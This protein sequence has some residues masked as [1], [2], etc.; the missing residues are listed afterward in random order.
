MPIP[1]P[2]EDGLTAPARHIL[3]ALHPLPGARTF[4]KTDKILHAAHAEDRTMPLMDLFAILARMVQ[5][6]VCRYPVLEAQGNFGSIDGDPPAGMRYTE[7]A[8][9]KDEQPP[10]PRLLCNG[11]WAHSGTFAAQP[12]PEASDDASLIDCVPEEPIQGGEL[13]SFLLPHN[14]GEVARAITLLL[15]RPRSSVEEVL[16]VLPGPD[17]PTGGILT[18]PEALPALYATGKGEARIRARMRVDTIPRNKFCVVISEIPFGM[19]KTDLIERMAAG[20]KD[21]SLTDIAD[22]R[23]MTQRDDLRI[24]IEAARDKDPAWVLH[25]LSSDPRLESVIQVRMVVRRAGHANTVGLIDLLRMSL[26]NLPNNPRHVLAEWALR[27]D[28]RRS[29]IRNS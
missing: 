13:L 19:S 17:F 24:E 8:R 29:T 28:A 6:W 1:I 2:E 5:P 3:R 9:F 16:R 4:I 22:I 7:L 12:N 18:N 27:S 14:L 25:Q 15:D 20:V 21:G 10:I 26:D 23:D 11:A